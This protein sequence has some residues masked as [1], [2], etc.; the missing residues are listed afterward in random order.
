MA[1]VLSHRISTLLVGKRNDSRNV[2]TKSA[3]V[4][5]FANACISLSADLDDI[6]DSFIDLHAMTFLPNLT[7]DP[8]CDLF[9]EKFASV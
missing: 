7:T 3:N 2:L 6:V 8:V 9:A 5:V 1:S 4:Y